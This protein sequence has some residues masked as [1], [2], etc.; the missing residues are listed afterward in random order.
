MRKVL[1]ILVFQLLPLPLMAQVYADFRT[2][3]GDFTCELNTNDT[4]RTTANF[5]TL[6]E[7]TRAWFD[8]TTGQVTDPA[9]GHSYYDGVGIHRIIDTGKLRL[10]H[11]G[12]RTGDS[13]DGPGYNFPDEFDET[14]P[15]TWRFDRPY[16][17]AMANA[18]PNTN[19]AQ[20]FVTGSAAPS[21]DG[22]YT[23]FGHV[24]AG[25][26]VVDQILQVEV[27]E[28]LKPLEPVVIEQITI[29]R[30]GEEAWDFDEFAIALPEVR[31]ADP[32]DEPE[33]EG[34]AQAFIATYP[35]D[36]LTPEA[37]PGYQLYLQN[38]SGEYL[39]CFTPTGPQTY[40]IVLPSGD[41]RTGI[42]KQ[43][44]YTPNGYSADLVIETE[45]DGLY[46][47]Q[48]APSALS[49]TGVLTGIQT[50]SFHNV[51]FGWVAYGDR[52]EFSWSPIR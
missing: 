46:R 8:G 4:P 15:E 35:D 49:N 16:L 43:A 27:D 30:E 36:V 3:H 26:S 17:L 11:A 52:S 25:Q 45:S 34:E 21:L 19:G 9:S 42:I 41:T 38:E 29:R 5:I 6:A 33:A 28:K 31:Q 12:S 2:S 24:T 13:T 7:G 23:I 40:L 39:F 37:L 51:L 18:G 44:F 1:C 14:I 32:E 48:L 22:N 10:F 50:G 20:F 47:Y